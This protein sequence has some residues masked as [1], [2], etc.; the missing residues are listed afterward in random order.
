MELGISTLESLPPHL[1]KPSKS[2][3]SPNCLLHIYRPSVSSELFLIHNILAL[4]ISLV[5][6]VVDV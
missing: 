2:V 3:K 4:E 5:L 1:H 6:N